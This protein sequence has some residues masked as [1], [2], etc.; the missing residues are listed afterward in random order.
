VTPSID[1]SRNSIDKLLAHHSI[2]NK[3]LKLSQIIPSITFIRL[4]LVHPVE[5]TGNPL[6]FLVF[7]AGTNDLRIFAEINV[8]IATVSPLQEGTFP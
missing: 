5:K 8:R 6:Q 3:L 2:M 1:N 7:F 4:D